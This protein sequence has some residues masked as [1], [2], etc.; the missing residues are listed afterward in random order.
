M[1]RLVAIVSDH[2]LKIALLLALIMRLGL[3][4]VFYDSIF[5]YEITGEIHGSAAYD[6][7]AQNLLETGVYGRVAGVPDANIP[8]LYSYIVAGIYG[9]FGRG[10]L[11]IGLLHIVLDM[12][13][14]LLLYDI[15]RR[16]FKQHPAHQWIA[17]LTLLTYAAYPYLIYQNL[18]LNDTA[19]FM[20]LMHAFVW[21]LVVLRERERLDHKTF[22]LAV[23]V[24][25]ILGITTL[26]RALLPLL[27]ILAALWFLFRLSFW[28][29]VLRLL[30]VALVSALVL[31]PW[32]WRNLQIYDAF[33]PVALNTGEN[34]Y[35]GNNDWTLPL[36][37]AGYDAQWSAPPPE[38]EDADAFLKNQLLTDAGIQ[39][40]R[41]NRDQLPDLLWTKFIVYWH[42]DIT[43][44]NNPQVGENLILENGELIIVDDPNSDLQD[45]E[46]LTVYSSSLFDTVGRPVHQLYFGGLLF[47]SLIGVGLSLSMWR[48]VSLLWFVQISM[49]IMYVIFH[50]STRYRVPTD[51][52]LF[53]FAAF[54]I[55]S[56]WCWFQERNTERA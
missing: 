12:L 27:A 56:I 20:L 38:A 17:T 30:P 37:R 39:W 15:V 33:V 14:M 19:L 26:G 3:L 46:T 35:Q 47:L 45:I 49:T 42:L 36:F 23:S 11:Q 21:G 5:G 31:V 40:L 43:P 24:G 25:V 44:R 53:A 9:T 29:T 41:N 28:Q 22:L 48:D 10:G 6:E 52:L 50:P 54:T 8:P 51:P 55:V 32:M 13:T 2:K 16:I 34:L 4:L 1:T 18:T 7:Y